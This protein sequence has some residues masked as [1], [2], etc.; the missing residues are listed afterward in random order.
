MLRVLSC[1]SSG[2]IAILLVGCDVATVVQS[3]A[4]TDPDKEAAE[5]LSEK[6]SVAEAKA[7]LAGDAKQ[8]VLWKGRGRKSS[9]WSTICMP[10]A[11]RKFLRWAFPKRPDLRWWPCL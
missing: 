8:H 6:G 9:S 7:W 10:R 3:V 11:S 4:N 5:M 2:F 1:C